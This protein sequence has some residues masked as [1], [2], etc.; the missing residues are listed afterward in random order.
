MIVVFDLVVR[1]MFLFGF[2]DVWVG[3]FR[4]VGYV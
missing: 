4:V 3:W 2:G 1:V